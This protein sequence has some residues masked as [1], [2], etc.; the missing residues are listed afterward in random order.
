MWS[1]P[2][3]LRIDGDS[4]CGLNARPG[5]VGATW[6]LARA[7][8]GSWVTALAE[9]KP[10]VSGTGIA[11]AAWGAGAAAAGFCGVV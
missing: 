9:K 2:G 7:S 6:P 10:T 3:V 8:S 5:F 11:A 4:A 1:M